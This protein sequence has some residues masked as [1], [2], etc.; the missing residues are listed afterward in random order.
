MITC[1]FFTKFKL[2]FWN[3]DLVAFSYCLKIKKTIFIHNFSAIDSISGFH[4]CVNEFSGTIHL[5]KSFVL[6]FYNEKN[7]DANTHFQESAI[8]CFMNLKIKQ[9][10]RMRIHA[11][12][13][14][15]NSLS[16][17]TGCWRFKLSVKIS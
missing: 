1:N 4:H 5:E 2:L 15:E 13:W 8:L 6:V 17:L 7:Y 9:F 3:Q 12:Q 16:Q 14:T 10:S 11:M